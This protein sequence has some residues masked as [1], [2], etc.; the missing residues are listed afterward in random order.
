[1]L[2]LTNWCPY[3]TEVFGFTYTAWS[4]KL[5]PPSRETPIQTAWKD[6]GNAASAALAMPLNT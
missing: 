2:T 1:M 5:W 6:V 3:E 4:V